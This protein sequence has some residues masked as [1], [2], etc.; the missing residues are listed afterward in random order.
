[1]VDALIG[2]GTSVYVCG[3]GGA[4]RYRRSAWDEIECAEKNLLLQLVDM[5]IEASSKQ[6]S[7]DS[8]SDTLAAAEHLSVLPP[9]P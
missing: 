8:E 4:L 9:E 6:M 1:L 3:I 2:G 5:G 7:V